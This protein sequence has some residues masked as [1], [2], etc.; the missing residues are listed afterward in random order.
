MNALIHPGIH[1]AAQAHLELLHPDLRA[2]EPR[3][4]HHLFRVDGPAFGE[5]A[6]G[7][8]RTRQG[9]GFEPIGVSALVNSSIANLRQ[10]KPRKA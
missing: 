1:D 8:D 2:A 5:C 6:A 9:W 4:S 3:I 10:N 7:E